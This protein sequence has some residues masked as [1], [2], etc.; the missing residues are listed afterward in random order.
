MRC[1]KGAA[2]NGP[3]ADISG[4]TSPYTNAA[5]GSPRFFRTEN[6]WGYVNIWR[7]EI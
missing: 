4:A 3:Y 1:R 7:K 5:A 2:V 6:S